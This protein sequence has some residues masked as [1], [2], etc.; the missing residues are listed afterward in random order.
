MQVSINQNKL[1]TFRTLF[2]LIKTLWKG[3]F[4]QEI[5]PGVLLK[6]FYKGKTL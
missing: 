6:Q 5:T 1:E 3:Y 4:Q 2:N